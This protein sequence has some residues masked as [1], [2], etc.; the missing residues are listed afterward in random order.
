MLRLAG[1]GEKIENELVIRTGS[2]HVLRNKSHRIC[3]II[4]H[5]NIGQGIIYLVD[6]FRARDRRDP[7]VS[8]PPENAPPRIICGNT[9]LFSATFS[10]RRIAGRSL[11]S[12]S[13]K[14]RGALAPSMLPDARGG[15]S[16]MKMIF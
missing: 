6:F 16:L 13:S 8:G 12:G 7:G 15:W 1:I 5:Q 3:K 2:R 11:I 14:G 4:L 10:A 9:A